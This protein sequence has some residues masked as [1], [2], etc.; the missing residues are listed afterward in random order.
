MRVFTAACLILLNSIPVFAGNLETVIAPPAE[1]WQSG[2]P[3]KFSVYIHN[4][5]KENV[6]LNLPGQVTCRFVSDE[7]ILELVAYA[8]Q[9]FPETPTLI[10]K[11]EFLKV[12][13]AFTVP[14][15]LEGPVRMEIEAFETTPVMFAIKAAERPE[16]DIAA[17][18]ESELSPDEV[19]LESLFTLYQPYLG[20]IGAYKAMYFLFGT[21]LE[22]SKFQISFKYQFFNPDNQLAQDH[23]WLKG[24]HFGYT[25]TSFWDL[26]SASAPFKDTSYKPEFFFISYNIN[27]RPSWM[28]G[29][30]VQTGFQHESNG[31]SGAY[32]RS[33]NFLYAKPIFIH[34]DEKSLFGLLV[35]P[36]IWTYVN[37]DNDSNP[38]LD[39]YRGFFDLE[40]KFGKADSLVLGSHL[41]WAEEGGSVQLDLTY[42]LH[43][44]IFKNIDLYLQVQ[45]V[46]ALAES[47]IDYRERNEALRFGFA[48]V[49]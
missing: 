28:K 11:S 47:L 35:A 34:Y 39:K 4:T 18:G 24:L 29:F 44:S 42:P 33:T 10:G 23:P 26:K 16:T 1:T 2:Q 31:R 13:Y 41:R 40:L 36:K 14:F 32:S 15:G 25:Q 8:V 49:R 3:V 45:Y 19:S 38:D 37:N 30:F 6:N 43:R 22:E 48:I 12:R 9:P 5:G 17:S 7:H 21:D 46:N 27:A 20:N